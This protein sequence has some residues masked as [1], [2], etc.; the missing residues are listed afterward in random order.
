[1]DAET[2]ILSKEK[3]FTDCSKGI[4]G[5]TKWEEVAHCS[6][7]DVDL[8]KMHCNYTWRCILGKARGLC[9]TYIQEALMWC[10]PLSSSEGWK[11]VQDVP[12]LVDAYMD[13]K[14]KLD[15]FITHSLPLDEINEAFETLKSGERWDLIGL[16][17]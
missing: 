13:N 17:L 9:H 16:C 5:L 6:F 3:K 15:E 12:K 11:S 10:G 8:S 1:M 2:M 7:E 4:Q 14:L